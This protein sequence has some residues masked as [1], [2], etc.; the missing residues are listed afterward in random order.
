MKSFSVC[1]WSL[2]LTLAYV[3][4]RAERSCTCRDICL[5]CL[6]QDGRNQAPNTPVPALHSLGYET[7]NILVI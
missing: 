4:V 5:R 7:T 6:K 3:D 2:D 1:C